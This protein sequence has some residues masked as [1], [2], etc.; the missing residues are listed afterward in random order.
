MAAACR[1]RI[2]RL[3]H[4]VWALVA[5]DAVSSAAL[6]GPVG[7][8]D[9]DAQPP[10]SLQ[11]PASLQGAPDAFP[12]SATPLS[13]ESGP[14]LLLVGSVAAAVVLARGGDVAFADATDALR[15]VWTD[16]D[17]THVNKS[18]DLGLGDDARL[19]AL[20]ATNMFSGESPTPQATESGSGVVRNNSSVDRRQTRGADGEP[21]VSAEP[22]EIAAVPLTVAIASSFA[23]AGL[24]IAALRVWR[25]RPQ[26]RKRT[27]LQ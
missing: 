6:A 10:K 16:A 11:I 14:V 5:V 22:R 21:R 15:A 12:I 3:A 20:Q 24:S 19:R 26:R 7:V 8:S 4:F 17:L 9:A 23:L 25:Q 2:R 27:R 13:G 18:D 1:P